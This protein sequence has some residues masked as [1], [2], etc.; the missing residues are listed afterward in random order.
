MGTLR[1]IFAIAVVL[2]HSW[3][4]GL[5]LVG[6]RN[7]VQ[8]FYII[9]GFLIS[10]VLTERKSY[11]AVGTFYVNRYLRLYPVYFCVACVALAVNLLANP[12]FADVYREIPA[13]AKALLILSNS[14]LF[15]QD[16]VM[17]A[18]VK[19]GHLVPS[20]NF[21]DSDVLLHQGLLVPQAWTLGVELSFYVLAPF[22][23]PRRKLIWG[24]LFASFML[25]AYLIHI[26]IGSSDPWTYRFFPTELA[27]F[28]CGSLA[29]QVLLPAY[30]RTLGDKAGAAATAATLFL[31]VVSLAYS[32]LPGSLHL[33]SL[34][35]FACF[36][37][38]IPLTFLF[39]N[40]YSFDRKI[41]ELSYPIYICH[42]LVVFAASNLLEATHRADVVVRT[43]ITVVATVIFAALLNACIAVPL[44]KVRLRFKGRSASPAHASVVPQARQAHDPA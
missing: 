32:W 33:K 6:G 1:T 20:S 41:G 27:L 30:E 39:Q 18:A 12:S 28:L 25:R 3:P 11:A 40:R 34:L 24:L 5:L 19:A 37:F 14:V 23:L 9:S 7:A 35:L 31:V 21:E 15:G 4:F 10:Y 42:M 38:L 22:V 17:F 44:E 29:H 13:S 26:G 36:I 2:M 16:W 8:L 43:I